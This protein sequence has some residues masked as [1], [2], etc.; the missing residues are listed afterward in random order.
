MVRVNSDFGLF[1]VASIFTGDLR[2]GTNEFCG[3]TRLLALDFA[4]GRD[5]LDLCPAKVFENTL[6]ILAAHKTV[7]P[8]QKEGQES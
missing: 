3:E 6:I 5:L 4:E 1:R 7:L 8:G 2:I